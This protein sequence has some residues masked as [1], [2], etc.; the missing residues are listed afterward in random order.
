MPVFRVKLEFTPVVNEL[1]D[2]LPDH[3][4]TSNSTRFLDP[5]FGGGQFLR[6]IEKRLRSAGHSQENINSRVFGCEI[7]QMRLNWTWDH[8]RVTSR[9]L[10]K[11]DFLFD[12]GWP[13]MKFDVIVGNPPYQD[14]TKP[15]SH[16]LWCQFVEKSM[17]LLQV[18]GH[19]AFVT[20]NVGRR[21]QVLPL[22]QNR[23]VIYYNG[24]DVKTHFGSVGSTFCAW[25]IENSP[26]SGDLT[27]VKT[28][29]GL[30]SVELG[31]HVAFV[32]LEL[33]P[34]VLEFMRSMT[35][36]P[37]KLDVRTDWGY[38]S[39]GKKEWFQD[40]P[41]KK[42]KYK[43]QNTSSSIKYCSED[44]EAIHKKKVIC[45]KSGYLKP[46]YDPGKVGVTENSWVIPVSSE[47]K[48][49]IIIDF[50][51]SE[52]VKRFVN[53]ATG[54]NTLV[55]DPHIYRMLNSPVY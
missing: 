24:H 7:T 41:T 14:P 39:H 17:Q 55:N 38:H 11:S 12:T 4:W 10:I 18:G 28:A 23:K 29:T 3:V 53:L 49:K 32:P 42:F 30:T 25:V 27:Q 20:P 40:T 43:F 13:D 33:E 52:P 2:Q 9:N 22:F 35:D 54:G 46:W 1:L 5:A 51:E 37:H 44:H 34:E 19:L 31:P 47:R 8:G 26:Y 6:E 15:N 36:Q 16:N 45:S 50:L 21:A 48:A